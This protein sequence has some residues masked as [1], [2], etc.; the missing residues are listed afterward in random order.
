MPCVLAADTEQR[1]Y[2]A[3]DPAGGGGI[4]GS[5]GA[6]VTHALAVNHD[7]LGVYRG[8]VSAAGSVFDFSHLPVG[9]YDLVMVTKDA[10]STKGWRSARK[11]ATCPAGSMENLK[12]AHREAGRVFQPR[13][14]HRLGFDGENL[15][16]FVERIQRP[17][18]SQ[19]GRR[20]AQG[21]PAAAGNHGNRAGRRRLAGHHD[22]HLYREEEPRTASITPCTV[23]PEFSNLRVID[24]VKDLGSVTAPL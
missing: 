12:T 1:I 8:A 3:P 9:K 19:A 24:G 2:T 20:G 17:A 16:L 18:N 15:S 7:R 10:R 22:A 5:C 11:S 4:K 13:A 23:L 14:I 21:E 6:K